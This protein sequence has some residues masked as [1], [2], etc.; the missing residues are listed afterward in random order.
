MQVYLHANRLSYTH[1][2]SRSKLILTSPVV[3]FY[4]VRKNVERPTFDMLE[5]C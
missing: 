2:S 4:F 5:T 1:T 3:S